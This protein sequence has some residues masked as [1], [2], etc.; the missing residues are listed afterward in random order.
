MGEEAVAG[1]VMRGIDIVEGRRNRGSAAALSAVR[2]RAS[3]VFRAGAQSRGLSV[4]NPTR[5][6]VCRSLSLS[7]S[8]SLG[9]KTLRV[10]D[11]D[12]N[13]GAHFFRAGVCIITLKP[14]RMPYE[15][16][17]G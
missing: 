5:G 2:G 12:P 6:G 10:T 17:A 16:P 9:S 13:S 7:L 3:A 4:Q 1:G 15:S 14:F 11:P 8:L